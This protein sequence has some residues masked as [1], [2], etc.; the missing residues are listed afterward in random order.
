MD[1]I[2]EGGWVGYHGVA[3]WVTVSTRRFT[4]KN[5]KIENKKERKRVNIENRLTGN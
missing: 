2:E 5:R 1:E 4:Q 3:W